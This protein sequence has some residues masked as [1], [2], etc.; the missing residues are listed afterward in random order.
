MFDEIAPTYDL[1]NHVLSFG[2]DVWWR[3]KAIDAIL[4]KR[5]GCFLDIA[6]GT[7]D[8]SVTALHA[9]P[10]HIVGLDFASNTLTIARKK[11]RRRIKP[12]MYNT[13]ILDLIAAD[14]QSIPFRNDSFDVILIAFGIRNFPDKLL[15]LRESYRVLRSDGRLCILELS[16]PNTPLFTPIFRWYFHTVVPLI[17]QLLSGHSTAYRYLPESVDILPEPDEIIEMMKEVGFHDAEVE[18]LT[19]GVATLFTA[20]KQ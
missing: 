14:V 8:F 16:R 20:K 3:R 18:P 19:F 6:A 2:L 17:G 5:G 1:L 10:R 15:A 9:Q 4:V 12:S 13:T 11:F 7:G